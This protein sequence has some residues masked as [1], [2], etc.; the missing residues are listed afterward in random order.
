M[1][2][3]SSKVQRLVALQRLLVNRCQLFAGVFTL[4]K[5]GRLQLLEEPLDALVGL[6]LCLLN[7]LLVLL[8]LPLLLLLL[9]T[10]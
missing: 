4:L 9:P 5:G 2:L 1:H 3:L 8:L 6:V 7:E 10:F